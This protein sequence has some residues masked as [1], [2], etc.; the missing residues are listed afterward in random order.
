MKKLLS[1]LMAIAMLLS[2]VTVA[3]ADDAPTKIS[4]MIPLYYSEA[5]TETNELEVM[6]EEYTNTDLTFLWTSI[7]NYNE[8][9]NMAIASNDMP[10]AMGVLNIKASMFVD[11]ARAGMFWDITELIKEYPNLNDH[12]KAQMLI[13]ASID[14]KLYGL[15]RARPLTRDGMIYRKDWAEN[16]GLKI[17]QPITLDGVYEIIKAFGTQDPDG[18]GENDTYGLLL[19]VN[20]DGSLS[21]M[22]DQILDV[23]N[24]GYNGWGINAEGNVESAYVTE[25]HLESLKWLKKLYDEGLVNKDFATVL[26]TQF[27]ELLDKEVAGFYIQT[28]TDAHERLDTIVANVQARTP[29]LQGKTAVD[30]KVDIFDTIYQ[31]ATKD[32][33]IRAHTQDGF[34]GMIVFPKSSN[35]TEE[36]LRKVLQFFDTMDSPEGQSVIYWGKEGLH[37]DYVNGLATMTSDSLLFSRDVQPYWQLFLTN[38]ETDRSSIK[39]YV[40]P[41]YTKVYGEMDSL[42]P[43]AVYNVS[44]PLLSD[45]YTEN[46]TYLNKIIHDAEIQFI[47]GMID[48]NGWWDAVARWR[49]A[50]GDQVAAEYTAQYKEMN[51]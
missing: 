25:A 1:V 8:K 9:I 41:M 22:V 6:M 38:R 16:L 10:N 44:V 23:A 46:S 2:I 39:G 43:Y 31:I 50:G 36:D 30:A 24:G 32:G 17:E 29:E 48:E 21:G 5:P 3:S 45:T 12:Y 33:E 15:P 7:D 19:G 37:W 18:N 35:P 51:P 26:N 47:M 11:A 34:N 42:M 4:V 20:S 13:N 27:Y 14:G 49:E 28:L 40:A